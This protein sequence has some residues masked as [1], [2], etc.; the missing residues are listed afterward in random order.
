MNICD[1]KK[2][3]LLTHLLLLLVFNLSCTE[4]EPVKFKKKKKIKFHTIEKKGKWDKQS[5]DH[6]PQYTINIDGDNWLIK[7]NVPFR[8]TLNPLHYVEV[9]VLADKNH[10]Q[11]Q[12]AS[13]VRGEKIPSAV[14]RLPRDN[15]SYVYIIS[16]CNLHDMWEKKV[17][18]E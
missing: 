12:K 4:Q 14:F 15:R 10:R 18:L 6:V 3:L 9:I 16:K 2:F 5:K 11:I 8:G 17:I 1:I 13:F 7:V